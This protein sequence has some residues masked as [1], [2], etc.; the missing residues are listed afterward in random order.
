MKQVHACIG[1]H[2]FHDREAGLLVLVLLAQFRILCTVRFSNALKIHVRRK[3]PLFFSNVSSVY[4][5]LSLYYSLHPTHALLLTMPNL[6]T[7]SS[8]P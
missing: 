6:A 4:H 5:Y 7:S 8:S 3:D 2:I 1:A